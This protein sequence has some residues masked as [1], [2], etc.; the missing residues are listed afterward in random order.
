MEN[1]DLRKY[2][3]EG[4]LFENALAQKLRDEATFAQA[5]LESNKERALNLLV[6]IYGNEEVMKGKSAA[7]VRARAVIGP[8]LERLLDIGL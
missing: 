7:S 2:L 8:S 6:G 1:F 3:A 4:K 5:T